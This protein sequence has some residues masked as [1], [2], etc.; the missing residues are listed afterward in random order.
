MKLDDF[1][2]YT[3]VPLGRTASIFA[4]AKV[5]QQHDLEA[6]EVVRSVCRGLGPARQSA[7]VDL[8]QISRCLP[9]RAASA[10]YLPVF[11]PYMVILSLLRVLRMIEVAC[12]GFAT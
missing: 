5:G 4:E 9:C 6:R 7:A 12:H 2:A 10:P 1:R 3:M 8:A 11:M